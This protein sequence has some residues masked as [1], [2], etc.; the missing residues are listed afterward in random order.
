MHWRELKHAPLFQP[1]HY[2]AAF[3]WKTGKNSPRSIVAQL[4]RKA[5][6][7]ITASGRVDAI[8]SLRDEGLYS[9]NEHAFTC[10]LALVAWDDVH[11]FINHTPEELRALKAMFPLTELWLRC[12]A[13]EIFQV[14]VPDKEKR[15]ELGIACANGAVAGASTPAQA[16]EPSFSAGWEALRKGGPDVPET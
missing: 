11:C 2:G 7:E 9:S 12:R 3:Y 13:A 8:A 10:M 14:F 4:R 15:H 16:V 6:E 1:L 5:A